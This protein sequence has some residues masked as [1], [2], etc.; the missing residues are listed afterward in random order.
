MAANSHC[1]HA[2]CETRSLFLAIQVEDLRNPDISCISIMCC[3]SLH[4][5]ARATMA[6]HHGYMV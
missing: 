6:P 2:S 3:T 5:S 4:F 1:E